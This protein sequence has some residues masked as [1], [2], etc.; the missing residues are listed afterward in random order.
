MV[1][2][3]VVQ[4]LGVEKYWTSHTESIAYGLR[5]A[6]Y[7]VPLDQETKIAMGSHVDPNLI[8]IICQHQIEGL[9]VQTKDGEWIHVEPFPNSLTVVIGE[10]FGVVTSFYEASFS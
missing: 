3:M 7:G 4:S 10:T 2:K 6:E 9:E 5:L 1:E 8:T